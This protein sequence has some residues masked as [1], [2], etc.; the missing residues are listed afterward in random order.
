MRAYPIKLEYA[1][2]REQQATLA[3]ERIIN[4]TRDPYLI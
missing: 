2:G 3:E 4:T 1:R